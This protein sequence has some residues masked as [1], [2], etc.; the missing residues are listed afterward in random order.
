MRFSSTHINIP[1]SDHLLPGAER[2]RLRTLRE[3]LAARR[4][5]LSAVK[6]SP[7]ST[8]HLASHE[9]HELNA[10]SASLARPRSGLVRELAEVFNVSGLFDDPGFSK[11]F[12]QI[13]IFLYLSIRRYCST[14]LPER[15]PFSLPAT[16]MEGSLA[17]LHITI[18]FNRKSTYSEKYRIF[19]TSQHDRSLFRSTETLCELLR[20]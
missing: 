10:L 17:I 5:T 11:S 15:L 6:L 8:T 20:D 19:T 12:E 18:Q 2:D 14:R 4:R 7:Q 1:A 13:I 3:N 9:T 16:A